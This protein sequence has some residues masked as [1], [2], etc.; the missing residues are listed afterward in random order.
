M[1]KSNQQQGRDFSRFDQMPTQDLEEYL[2]QDLELGETAT[3]DMELV[4][5]IMEVI[6][7]RDEEEQ[8]NKYTDQEV[9]W[10]RFHDNYLGF[11]D[12]EHPLHYDEGME[13]LENITLAQEDFSSQKLLPKRK[14]WKY[15]PKTAVAIIASFLALSLTAQAFGFNVWQAIGQWTEDVFS[16]SVKT[17]EVQQAVQ[18]LDISNG[19]SCQ[20]PTWLPDGYVLD[21]YDTSETSFAKTYF[22]WFTKDET[23]ISISISEV[24]KTNKLSHEKDDNQVVVYPANGVDYY[25]FTNL[26]QKKIMWSNGDCECYIEGGFSEEEA[27]KII[28]S[29]AR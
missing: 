12:Y 21:G 26:Q 23:A 29:I 16:F 10:A 15:F 13:L 6:A 7:K 18:T 24:V 3:S 22:M 17:S 4:L 9:A 28:D 2:A 11:A 5:Y 19:V 8:T 1:P 20:I 27:K 25:I 14:R